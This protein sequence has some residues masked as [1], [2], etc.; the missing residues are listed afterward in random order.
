MTR[1]VEAADLEESKVKM[2]DV[3]EREMTP[4]GPPPAY[5]SRQPSLVYPTRGL[6]VGSK[7]GLRNGSG[8]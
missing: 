7:R 3:P 2:L 8:W 6:Y 1:E 5:F 4:E